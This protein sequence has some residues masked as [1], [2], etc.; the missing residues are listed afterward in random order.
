M[1]MSTARWLNTSLALLIAAIILGCE[2]D[3]SSSAA[4]GHDFGPNDRD[5]AVAIGDSITAG[6][7]IGGAAAY[8]AQLSARSGKT[9]VNMGVS[10]QTSAGGGGQL[11]A[12]LAR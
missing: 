10:G 3:G 9:G 12:A 11:G 7:G 8:P 5:L 4:S 2:R 1:V 6:F